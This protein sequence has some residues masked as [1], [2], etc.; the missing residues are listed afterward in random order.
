[1]P[2]LRLNVLEKWY[3]SVN[4]SRPAISLTGS[5]VYASRDLAYSVRFRIRYS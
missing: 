2:V 5:S 3:W 4:P 1:M